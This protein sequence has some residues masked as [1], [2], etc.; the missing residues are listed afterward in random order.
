MKNKYSLILSIV[1]IAAF[2]MTSCSLLPAEDERLDPPVR[3][4]GA[5]EYRTEKVIRGDIFKNVNIFAELIP[6]EE[7]SYR[8]KVFTG[9]IK[10]VYI[11]KG[12]EVNKGDLIAILDTGTLDKELRDMSLNY[13]VARINYE[14]QKERYS[15]KLI[16][17]HSMKLAEIDYLMIKAK[18][19]DL[20]EK[21]NESKIYA[22]ED[23]IA[24]FVMDYSRNNSI[25]NSTLIAKIA[26]NDNL[27]LVG[28]G[29]NAKNFSEGDV[30][31]I[32]TIDI[33]TS[34]TV[35]DVNGNKVQF[36]PEIMD[37]KWG[38]GTV[39]RVSLNV[40]SAQDVLLIKQSA[41]T[42]F[43]KSFV[44]VLENGVAIEK[45][46]ETGIS[47]NSYI[48]VISGLEEGEEVIIY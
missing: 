10:E 5:V 15:R 41:I 48:E 8:F 19:D 30:V 47:D 33:K 4:A 43:A 40:A 28:S 29:F 42:R 37:D 17:E 45:E 25:T 32:E 23:G 2:I 7:I 11:K 27:I 39:M 3:E 14:R 13:E 20:L 35:S 31:T 12:D 44:R 1:L 46:I 36:I 21:D 18:Y 22:E 24:T 9:T 38:I 34:G 6:A 16:S 26:N